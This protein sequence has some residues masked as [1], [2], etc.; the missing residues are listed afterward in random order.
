MK[1]LLQTAIL[2]TLIMVLPACVRNRTPTPGPNPGPIVNP[3]DP[4]TDAPP[5][6]TTG[7]PEFGDDSLPISDA[8]Y[9]GIRIGVAIKSVLSDLGKPLVAVRQEDGG[10]ALMYGIQG[11]TARAFF[12]F[13]PDNQMKRKSRLG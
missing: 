11:T 13:G 3:L 10:I 6:T 9:D 1:R 7:L 12:V 5:A 4:G 8:Q 2:V